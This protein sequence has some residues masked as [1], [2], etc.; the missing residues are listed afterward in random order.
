MADREQ[1]DL[2]TDLLQDVLASVDKISKRLKMCRQTI[3]RFG[4]AGPQA[5]EASYRLWRS[6]DA[7]TD[8]R[9]RHGFAD[10]AQ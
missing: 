7:L 3:D 9:S 5:L 8:I 10:V 2:C 4:P 6:L 1:D